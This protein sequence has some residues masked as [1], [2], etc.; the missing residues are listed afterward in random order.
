MSL[1][2]DGAAGLPKDPTQSDLEE[3]ACSACKDEGQ[4]GKAT[5]HVWCRTCK[6]ALCSSHV[7][8]HVMSGS[9]PSSHFF[10]ELPKPG[11][12]VFDEPP[13]VSV[14][15]EHNSPL[16]Y[17]CK[18]CNVAVCG[19][20]TAIGAH[21]GHR[22]VVLMKDVNAELHAKVQAK[23][24][25]LKT[26]A[27][28]HVQVAI[29]NVDQVSLE[30]T[31]GAKK[32]RGDVRAA[33]DRAVDTIR[34]SEQQKLQEIEDIE[35]VR[36]KGLDRQK[37]ELKGHAEA[38][39]RAIFLT[40]KLAETEGGG[41]AAGRLLDAL[42]KRTTELE[43]TTISVTPERHSRISFETVSDGD[44]IAKA[45]ELVGMVIPCEASAEQSRVEGGYSITA[46]EGLSAKFTVVA[47]D[48][49][50][51]PATQGGDVVRAT[52]MSKPAKVGYLPPMEVRD[53]RN[54]RYDIICPTPCTGAYT[55]EISING[56]SL[57]NTLSVTCRNQVGF[58]F[59]QAQCDSAITISPD[60][61]TVTQTGRDDFISMVLG[62]RGVR[63]GQH[64]WRVR[65]N[66]SQGM[67]ITV[68]VIGKDQLARS[69][70]YEGPYGWYASGGQKLE[71]GNYTSSISPFQVNDIIQ[72][73]VDCEKHTLRIFNHRSAETATIT[74]L[75]DVELFPYF[76]TWNENDSL[77]LIW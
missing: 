64:S 45:N 73:D 72:L 68:G 41:R 76:D 10:R 58:R 13:A 38:L 21:Q 77:S 18:K 25:R 46:Q 43:S 56:A 6:C 14:C 22:P 39:K 55:V 49:K 75:P 67:G 54:G 34:A 17:L 61:L 7:G 5:V 16:E 47:K 29:S 60:K 53:N 33:A 4:T 27:L 2:P 23:A 59:D 69:D 12:M 26:V 62:S 74:G 71:N 35:V 40:D 36:L 44:L 3:Y 65:L 63:R 66:H 9:G 42:E 28:P 37:D 19:G 20:C 8:S 1:P 32:L 24:H 30:L 48:N 52:M 11:A 31:E 51:N 15:G 50:G 57:A 70:N